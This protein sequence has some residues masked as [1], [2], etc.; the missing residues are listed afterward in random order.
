MDINNNLL[1]F[2]TNLLEQNGIP[3][4]FLTAPSDVTEKV[5]L[6]LRAGI[7]EY[8]RAT[9]DIST[10]FGTLEDNKVYFVKDIFE[11][12]YVAFRLPA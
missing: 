2:T 1:Q 7:L 8:E 10:F 6:G 4:Q 11:C 3:V 5:D 12:N 9:Q